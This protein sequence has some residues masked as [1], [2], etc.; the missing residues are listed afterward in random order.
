MRYLK[1]LKTPFLLSAVMFAICGLLYPALTTGIAQ[2]IFPYQAG[3]SL[4]EIGGKPVGSAIVGQ[5]FTDSRLMKCRPSAVGYNTYTDT[6]KAD[7]SYSGVGSGSYNYAP[8]NSALM[9]RVERDMAAFLNANPSAEH[10]PADIMTA[11][12]S[13]LDPHISVAAAMVQIPALAQN[14][15]ITQKTLKMIARRNTEDKLFGIFG[16]R[17][18]NVLKVNL[19]IARIIDLT[20]QH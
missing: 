15:G 14:T 4:I 17:V 2:T 5:N 3:G 9:E 7:G 10:I 20:E 8:S 18:V 13:G 12:G 19:E 16:E 11:S 1:V 6:E